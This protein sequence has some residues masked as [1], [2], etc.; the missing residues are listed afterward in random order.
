MTVENHYKYVQ[1]VWLTAQMEVEVLY[2]GFSKTAKEKRAL[3]YFDRGS[4]S[5][6][7][8]LIAHNVPTR[9]EAPLDFRYV[10]IY[11]VSTYKSRYGQL[12]NMTEGWVSVRRDR[13]ANGAI[14]RNM[15]YKYAPDIVS[16]TVRVGYAEGIAL[17]QE[18]EN[19]MRYCCKPYGQEGD[20]ELIDR[21]VKENKAW[22]TKIEPIHDSLKRVQLPVYNRMNLPG[23]VFMMDMPMALSGGGFFENA[24]QLALR[25]R[26]KTADDFSRMPLAHRAVVAADAMQAIANHVLYITDYNITNAG[27]R[28]EVDMFSSISRVISG[29]DCEDSAKEIVML[30]SELQRGTFSAHPLAQAASD[31]LRHYVAF[32]ALGTVKGRRLNEDEVCPSPSVTLSR[33]ILEHALRN[34]LVPCR[35]NVPPHLPQTRPSSVANRKGEA[36]R[37]APFTNCVSDLDFWEALGWL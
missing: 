15:A 32:I 30:L 3:V 36:G 10:C 14:D 28:T 2:R 29:G 13:L 35:S 33:R 9:I 1:K 21:L 16:G 37:P 5:A 27:K 24:I 6:A 4:R 22:Y 8:H 12:V 23:W 11:S 17:D 19:L 34:H 20:N 18:K 7:G 31:A 25:R 26:D